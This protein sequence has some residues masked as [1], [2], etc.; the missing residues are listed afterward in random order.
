MFTPPSSKKPQQ[1]FK[2]QRINRNDAIQ[3]APIKANL[4]YHAP[5]GAYRNL[6]VDTSDYERHLAQVENSP[7]ISAFP[8]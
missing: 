3:N 1:L 2:V 7:K 5:E 6:Y 8:F 4:Y